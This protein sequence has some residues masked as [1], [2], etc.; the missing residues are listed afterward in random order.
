MV[1]TPASLLQGNRQ[2]GIPC[3]DKAVVAHDKQ[4][5]CHEVGAE[6]GLIAVPAAFVQ[7]CSDLST[8][9][10]PSIARKI[11]EAE[12]QSRKFFWVARLEGVVCDLLSPFL[13][14]RLH[15]YQDRVM[16]SVQRINL[17]PTSAC[18]LMCLSACTN[19]ESNVTR[20]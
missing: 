15:R 5:V 18:F 12:T 14:S 20:C 2:A 16:K 4:V 19:T 1:L 3:F 8:G 13:C 9:L 10:A 17:Q 6:C 11:W 7:R